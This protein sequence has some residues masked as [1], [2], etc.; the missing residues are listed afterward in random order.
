MHHARQGRWP[1]VAC[2]ISSLLLSLAV[3]LA[4][5]NALAQNADNEKKINDLISKMTLQEKIQMLGGASMMQT[6]G[7]PRLGIPSFHTSDGP[8]G[9][10]IPAAFD[11]LRGRNR[12]GRQLGPRSGQTGSG[13]RLAAM[14]ARAE[15][16]FILAPASTSIGRR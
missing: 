5:T 4:G 10:H 15:R 9:A 11:G 1:R 16:R 6:T 7:I 13:R 8:S 12:A 3:L 2:A 14:P